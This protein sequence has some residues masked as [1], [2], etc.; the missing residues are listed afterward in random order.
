VALQECSALAD[1]W[2]TS[3]VM[4]IG[5]VW[6]NMASK[7]SSKGVNERSRLFVGTI[8]SPWQRWTASPPCSAIRRTSPQSPGPECKSVA[9]FQRFL[10]AT[11]RLAVDPGR[12]RAVVNLRHAV[13]SGGCVA[14]VADAVASSKASTRICDDNDRQSQH[15][16]GLHRHLHLVLKAN[17]PLQIRLGGS[18]VY[19][20]LVRQKSP[21]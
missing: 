5:P 16:F 14:V 10:I 4:H 11:A 9:T 1:E 21:L 19:S 2:V 6:P 12:I 15:D 7:S 17:F 8:I 20:R 18:G 13:L 3:G